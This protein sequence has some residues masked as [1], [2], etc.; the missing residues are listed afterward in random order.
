LSLIDTVDAHASL[1]R[2]M[3]L[4]KPRL[5]GSV[6]LTK[7]KCVSSLGS[8]TLGWG[9]TRPTLVDANF[10]SRPLGLSLR[11]KA[12]GVRPLLGRGFWV[13]NP[14]R[15]KPTLSRMWRVKSQVGASSSSTSVVEGSLVQLV[16]L[17]KA[18]PQNS[19][20]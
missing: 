11:A 19:E 4:L 6:V 7:M 14:T 9:P 2:P 15:P 1:L 12:R 17:P 10:S 13:K 18:S 3:G 8:D 5:D 20:A 16:E